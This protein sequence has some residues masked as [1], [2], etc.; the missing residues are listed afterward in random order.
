VPATGPTTPFPPPFEP[1]G[2]DGTGAGGATPGAEVEAALAAPSGTPAAGPAAV[3]PP[4]PSGAVVRARP[5]VGFW[6]HLPAPAPLLVPLAAGLTV[7]VGLVLGPLGRPSPVVRREGGLSRAL[8]RR[9][10][11]D[12]R[13]A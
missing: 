4:G 9:A 11:A 3:P 13:A 7:L 1:S 6:E 8:A 5:V 12:G 2:F 10:A